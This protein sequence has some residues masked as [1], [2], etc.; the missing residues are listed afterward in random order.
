VILAGDF[1]SDANGYV[2]PTY[3]NMT[4]YF[5]ESWKQAG[6]KFGEAKGATCCQSGTLKSTKRLDSG[7]PVIPTRIDLIL[8][9]KAVAVWKKID[10]TKLMQKKQP[11][12]QSDH[13]FY[14]AA[15]NLKSA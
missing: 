4:K 15:I 2:S 14:S 10:G 1:N 7:D 12:W 13:Y 9:R 6:G 5:K 3:R 11:V 8:N